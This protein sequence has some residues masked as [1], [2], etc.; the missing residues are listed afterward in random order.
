ME[1]EITGQGIRPED[2][3][4]DEMF[5]IRLNGGDCVAAEERTA[6][7]GGDFT[8]YT[9]FLVDCTTKE[10]KEIRFLFGKHLNPLI[11]QW[12]KKTEDWEG[13]TINIRPKKK[14]EFW[15][16]ELCPTE[17]FLDVV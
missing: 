3:T 15:D 5:N 16:V 9:L 4:G 13:N 6:K 10:D 12:G 2:L 7:K 11:K 17:T 14:G 1:I 8:Q